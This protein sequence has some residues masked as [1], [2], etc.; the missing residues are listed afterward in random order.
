MNSSGYKLSNG[1]ISEINWKGFGDT[2]PEF[3]WRSKE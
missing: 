3:A 2:I 1:R